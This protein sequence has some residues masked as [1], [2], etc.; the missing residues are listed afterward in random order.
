MLYDLLMESGR[1]LCDSFRI[2]YVV[3]T[4]QNFVSFKIWLLIFFPFYRGMNDAHCVAGI[5]RR[6]KMCTSFV[7][8]FVFLFVFFLLLFFFVLF[9]F[10]CFFCCIFFFCFVFFFFF[11]FFF[12]CCFFHSF[13]NKTKN[14]QLSILIIWFQI[15]FMQ[16]LRENSFEIKR[17]LNWTE[18]TNDQGV[19]IIQLRAAIF[20]R[21]RNVQIQALQ[22]VF[23]CLL[24]VPFLCIF[25]LWF[26]PNR[27]HVV[28]NDV[29][30][31]SIT[32]SLRFTTC[33]WKSLCKMA[34]ALFPL[35]HF[36]FTDLWTE[37]CNQ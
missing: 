31:D 35:E 16:N 6:T 12:L 37:F 10:S 1:N 28:Y 11:V 7:F 24:S 22:T 3:H 20:E 18:S 19:M 8:A 27:R 36:S 23:I 26:K 30:C 2:L 5:A 25:H 4:A 9:F 34:S 13:L 14:N 33:Y 17:N 29:T 32:C 21:I 15:I